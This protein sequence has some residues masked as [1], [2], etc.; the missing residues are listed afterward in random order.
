MFVIIFEDYLGWNPIAVS[1]LDKV[2]E[3]VYAETE[4]DMLGA[5]PDEA[6]FYIHYRG[7]YK[8]EMANRDGDCVEGYIHTAGDWT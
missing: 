2:H 1:S 3:A 7:L 8:L 6:T 5:M 4:S